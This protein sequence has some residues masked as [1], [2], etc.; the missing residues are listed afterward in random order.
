MTK[1]EIKEPIILVNG[2]NIL[3]KD[4]RPKIL[5]LHLLSYIDFKNSRLSVIKEN[6]SSVYDIMEGYC[7]DKRNFCQGKMKAELTRMLSMIKSNRYWLIREESVESIQKKFYDLILSIEGLSTLPGF[8][9]R[10]SK[11]DLLYGNPE[12]KSIDSLR[13]RM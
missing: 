8:G 9:A 13:S 7:I 6:L 11:G 4:M 10:N 5:F 2:R 3:V 1:E 12:R